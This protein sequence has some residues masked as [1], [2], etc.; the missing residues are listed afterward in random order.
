MSTGYR[1]HIEADTAEATAHATM[2]SLRAHQQ[3]LARRYERTIA[4][5]EAMSYVVTEADYQTERAEE[6]ACRS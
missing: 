3:D 2:A 4:E 6:V 5:I 1:L